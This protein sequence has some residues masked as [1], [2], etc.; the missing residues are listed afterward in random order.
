V[1]IPMGLKDLVCVTECFMLF[2]HCKQENHHGTRW[3]LPYR[4]WSYLVLGRGRDIQPQLDISL[5][6][7][8]SNRTVRVK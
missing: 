4:S 3:P 2:V 8:V 6:D 7:I 1:L 5:V